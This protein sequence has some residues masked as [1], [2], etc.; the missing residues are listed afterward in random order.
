MESIL[1]L[2]YHTTEESPVSN[3]YY[4]AAQKKWDALEPT[5]SL[6]VIDAAYSLKEEWGFS[7]FAAG[8][9]CGLAL[10]R[11]LDQL[12]SEIGKG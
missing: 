1:E 11:E 2:L 6:D 10:T 3:P 8:L 9:Q 5:L 7:C 4:D 12:G